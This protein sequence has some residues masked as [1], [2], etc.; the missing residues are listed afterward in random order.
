[1]ATLLPSYSSCSQQMTAG[2]R[3][4]AQR[5][6]AKLEEDYWLWY[7]VRVGKKQLR[8]DFMVLHPARGLLVLEVKDWKLDTIQQVAPD[9]FTLLTPDGLVRV[10]NP[11]E[12]ARCYALE[13]NQL[14]Q[15]D[16]ALV[17]QDGRYQGKLVCPYGYGVV[18]TNITRQQFESQPALGLVLPSNLVICQDEFYERVDPLEFQERLWAMMPYCFGRSLS[19]EQIN[20]VRFHLFPEMRVGAG[21][22]TGATDVEDMAAL[23]PDVIRMMDQQQEQLAR[24][25]GEGHRVIHGVAGSGKTMILAYRCQFLAQD[26]AKPILVLCFN[27]SLAS[28]LRQLMAAQG[29]GQRVQVRHFHGWCIEQLRAHRLPFPD[30]QQ[31]QG[32]AYIQELVQRV[33]EAVDAGQIAGGRYGAVMLDEGHDFQ[34]EWLKL[35]AQM[36]DP[37]TNSLLILYDDAQSIYEKQKRRRFTFASVGIKAQGRTTILKLNYR[38]T[39][40]VLQVAAAFAKELLAPEE[41]TEEDEPLLVSPESAGRHGPRPELIR[42]P[43]FGREVAYLADRVRQLH[44]QG[45]AW[46]EMAILY[47]SKFMAERICADFGRSQ[48]PVEWVNRTQDSRNYDAAAPSIK[49]LTMHA[50]KGLEFPVVM[51]PG[52]GFLPNIHGTEEDEARLLYVAMT[53]AMDRLV[54]TGD[55]P[56]PFVQRLEGVLGLAG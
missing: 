7:D 6:E 26:A 41:Q 55:R 32:E 47:R 11:L 30:R 8:P 54:L 1:M 16:P 18:L 39:V 44:E 34:P 10:K 40:E 33:I 31:F 9:G 25:L 35:V 48:I 14:L 38:N 5:L 24:S 43:S 49:L 46:N 50:S 19:L 4:L 2:E 12:Q 17:A 42:L 20:R 28:K 13:V 15:R 45:T 53:R 21:L 56:S 36:V 23:I 52:V 22:E 27:V 29:L 3:R 37:E 51:I